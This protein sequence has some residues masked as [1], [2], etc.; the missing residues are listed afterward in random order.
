MKKI[1][2]VFDKTTS[3]EGREREREDVAILAKCLPMIAC[4]RCRK[5]DKGENKKRERCS[6]YLSSCSKFL[7]LLF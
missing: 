6:L 3:L 4:M 7:A 5:K 1:S 2:K